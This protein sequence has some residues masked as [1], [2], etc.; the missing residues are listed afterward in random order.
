MKQKQ[1]LLNTVTS[2]VAPHAGAWIETREIVPATEI[3]EVAPHAG[4][5]IETYYVDNGMGRY[6]SPPTR[7]RGL[8]QKKMRAGCGA[9]KVAPHAGAWIETEYS[10]Q[11]PRGWDVAPTRKHRL[12]HHH[13]M[14]RA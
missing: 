8:K 5:W 3:D 4:A 12:K 11:N 13:L 7:G 2:T 6:R 1:M 14:V 10:L 9:I